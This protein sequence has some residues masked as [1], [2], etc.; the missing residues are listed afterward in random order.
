MNLESQS[1]LYEVS[2]YQEKGRTVNLYKQVSK[3]GLEKYKAKN[4]WQKRVYRKNKNLLGERAQLLEFHLLC[5]AIFK[6]D[7]NTCQSCLITR[8]KL[9][10]DKKFLTAHHI[11]PREEYDTNETQN[12]I[13]LCNDCHDKIEELE[14]KTREEITGYFS[15]GHHRWHRKE[16][17]GVTWQQWVYGGYQNPN[18]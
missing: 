16:N 13:T 12:L 9:L 5:K 17:I 1:E 11:I 8:N 7:R 14:I 10:V 2:S 3:A 4:Q 15:R 6:R 18:K